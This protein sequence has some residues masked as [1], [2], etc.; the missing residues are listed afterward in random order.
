MCAL[1]AM[2]LGPRCAAAQDVSLCELVKNPAAYDGRRVRVRGEAIPSRD[3]L[4]AS[5]C[6][7]VAS[8]MLVLV[9]GDDRA[10][11]ERESS[12]RRRNVAPVPVVNDAQWALF[13]EKL[14]AQRLLLPDLTRCSG[15]ECHFYRVT[16]TFTGEFYATGPANAAGCC[17]LLVVSQV[18]AVTPQRTEVPL[19]G[20]FQCSSE[21]WTPAAEPNPA[22]CAAC[23]DHN[24]QIFA[25][26]AKHWGDKIDPRPG[27]L[28][29]RWLSADLLM[30]YRIENG[31]GGSTSVVRE[32]CDPIASF[33]ARPLSDPASCETR[34]WQWAGDKH[35]AKQIQQAMNQG[36]DT[37]RLEVRATSRN[38]IEEAHTS[39]RLLPVDPHLVD[40]CSNPPS[41]KQQVAQ[42]GWSSPDGMHTYWVILEKFGYLKHWGSNWEHIPWIASSV[43][44]SF[45]GGEATK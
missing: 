17:S 42:C 6:A 44:G 9:N 19:G 43:E 35:A 10:G 11:L 8:G 27:M 16:A 25:R 3:K 14:N 36:R 41:Y 32:V 20:Q 18:E 15:P 37:W 26:A 30:T 34:R 24:A 45:C 39:W 12:A 5:G 23:A 33:P 4:E 13:G 7:D 22:G 21:T 40:N 29:E 28:E 1:V 38:A 31:S 2:A